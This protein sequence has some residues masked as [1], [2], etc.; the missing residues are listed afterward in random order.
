MDRL[1]CRIKVTDIHGD[2]F[3]T[4][5][6]PC[7]IKT[8]KTEVVHAFVP[9]PD[10]IVAVQPDSVT[11]EEITT[12]DSSPLL[13]YVFFDTG[14]ST[15]PD[16][17]L[18]LSEQSETE[19]FAPGRLRGTLE[20]YH[21][22]LNIIGQRLQTNGSATVSLVGCT[23][24]YG[25]EKGDKLLARLRAEAVKSYLQYVWRIDPARI[26]V[27]ARGLPS[28]P[29]TN[30][31]PEGRVENQ[32]VEILSEVY[33]ILDTVESQYIENRTDSR[34]IDVL[35]QIGS[36]YGLATWE[37]GLF[38]AG[39]ERLDRIMGRTG[40]NKVHS[41]NLHTLG[42]GKISTYDYL[43]VHVAAEDRKG[44]GFTTQSRCT[45]NFVEKEERIA[46]KMGYTVVE[47]YALILFDFDSA[48]IKDRNKELV[49]R[50]TQRIEK[51]PSAEVRVV[52]HT[53]NI[54]KEDYNL[55]LSIKRAKAV[56]DQLTASG[57]ID[58][59]RRISYL[60]MG[61]QEPLYDND[62]PEGR[63]LNR[64]VTVYLE[65]EDEG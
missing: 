65:Y 15:I 54:G 60:G 12:I 21:H 4:T 52:G 49:E 20:K 36:G 50:I 30:R 62:S 44:Q 43:L 26:T 14:Q 63:A 48:G 47:K 58:N 35:P 45:V 64:T 61:P 16:R 10:G 34:V 18:L 33:D 41:F 57:A 13:N 28:T 23:S 38:G 56:Y 51:L 32:R 31:I 11:I 25:P 40:L 2:T 59:M 37:I 42:L 1:E 8:S 19:A 17:Y 9:P 39:K 46:Q 7:L 24:D 55:K 22:L 27:S 6:P 29:S 5:A 53:D 3:E